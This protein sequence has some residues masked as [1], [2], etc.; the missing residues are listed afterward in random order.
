[1]K[2]PGFRKVLSGYEERRR[3]RWTGL[4]Q[5]ITALRRESGRRAMV[6]YYFPSPDEAAMLAAVAK[7][8]LV[9]VLSSGRAGT[10]FLAQL[11][12]SLPGVVTRHHPA[13]AFE[14]VLAKLWTEPDTARRFWLDYKLPAILREKTAKYLETS[15]VF[16]KGFLEPL[17]ALGIRPRLILLGRRPRDIARSYLERNT[18]PGRTDLGLRFMLSPDTPGVLPVADWR[19]LTDYQLCY[20]MAVEMERRQLRAF[21]LMSALDGVAIPIDVTDLN[22]VGVF[23]AMID[24][25]GFND[26]QL[27]ATALRTRLESL[28]SKARNVNPSRLSLPE[29]AEAEEEALWRRIDDSEPLLRDLVTARYG[30]TGPAAISHP[31]LEAY[32]RLAA[33]R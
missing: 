8:N 20:W 16:G 23:T 18:I 5:G 3:W 6:G 4:E 27:D 12:A 31:M 30:D 24:A 17:I 1:M 28:S 15:N 21:E 7:V 32:A 2:I 22:R 26:E 10:T 29:T 11:L 14:W 13:P 33:L 19:S 9:F 25:L